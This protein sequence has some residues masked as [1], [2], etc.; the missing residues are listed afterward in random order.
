MKKLMLIAVVVIL[1]SCEK[2]QFDAQYVIDKAIEI[3]GGSSYDQF[4]MEFDFRGR[5]YISKRDFRNF[6]YKRITID[7]LGKTIDTY[8]NSQPFTRVRNGEVIALPDSL[9][10]RIENSINSVNYFILL[11]YGLNDEA[12]NKSL[13]GTVMIKGEP[14]HKIK[15]T[16]S[17]EGG[18]TDYEDIFVYWIHAEDYTMDYLAYRFFTDEGGWRFR[19]AINPRKIEGIRF[20]DYRNYKPKKVP[21]EITELHKAFENGELQILSLI[22]TENI[23]VR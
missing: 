5:H 10:K 19:E 11:P 17:E 22:E 12:V 2:K 15:V 20:A 4:E 21:V 23:Q 6:E 14:Y 7:S 18:G 13:L 1:Y 3:S 8:S 9:G 16:F